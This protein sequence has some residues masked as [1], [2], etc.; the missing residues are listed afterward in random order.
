MVIKILDEIE[1]NHKFYY[2][3]AYRYMK[4]HED[5]QDVLQNAYIRMVTKYPETLSLRKLRA[6]MVIVCCNEAKTMLAVRNRISLT[7]DALSR[8][9]EDISHFG[10]PQDLEF[11]YDDI[12]YAALKIAPSEYQEPLFEYYKYSTPILKLSKNYC[13]PEANLRYWR[14]KVEKVLKNFLF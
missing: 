13:S 14:K 11:F 3:I 12:T 1:K 7:N 8:E 6:W 10:N 2:A 5:A 9:S 4:N